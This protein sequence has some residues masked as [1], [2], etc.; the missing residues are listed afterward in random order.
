MLSKMDPEKTGSLAAP[1]PPVYVGHGCVCGSGQSRRGKSDHRRNRKTTKQPIR[2]L[3]RTGRPNY[4]ELFPR[5]NVKGD[6]L[7]DRY[8]GVVGKIE[9][10]NSTRPASVAAGLRACPVHGWP[11]PNPA[12]GRCVH[13][14]P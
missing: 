8:I 7:Q 6:I 4:G 11:H 14:W 3:L 2:V 12:P 1:R 9:L 13:H 5:S 10:L